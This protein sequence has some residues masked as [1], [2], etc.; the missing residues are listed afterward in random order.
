MPFW[1]IYLFYARPLRVKAIS[2]LEPNV[3]LC[4]WPEAGE[5][6]DLEVQNYVT[7]I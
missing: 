5:H 7:V 2:D 1:H 6:D 4:L 3:L